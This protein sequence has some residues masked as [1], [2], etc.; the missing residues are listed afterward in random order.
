MVHVPVFR[1]VV[2]FGKFCS[3]IRHGIVRLM[4]WV[5]VRFLAALV[6]VV[7]RGAHLPE[8]VLELGEGSNKKEFGHLG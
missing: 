7:H 1:V 8:V 4:C 5:S 6:I 2:L 3:L